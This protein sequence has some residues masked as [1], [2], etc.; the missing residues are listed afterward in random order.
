MHWG[1]IRTIIILP[2]TVLVFVPV[3]IWMIIFFIA[4]AI[5]FPFFEEKDL[6]NRYGDTYREYKANVPRWIPRLREG[7]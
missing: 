6:E 4:N 3:C 2:G 5:Y 7:G 1:L